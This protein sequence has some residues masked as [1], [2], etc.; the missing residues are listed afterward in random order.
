MSLWPNRQESPLTIVPR[1]HGRTLALSI[2]GFLGPIPNWVG[3]YNARDLMSYLAVSVAVA[4]QGVALDEA[5][6]LSGDAVKSRSLRAGLT[7]VLA[8]VTGMSSSTLAS[9][10]I[11]AVRPTDALFAGLAGAVALFGAKRME[12]AIPELAAITDTVPDLRGSH[13]NST[14]SFSYETHVSGR[15]ARVTVDF[16]DSRIGQSLAVSRPDPLPTEAE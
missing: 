11:A 9:E 13:L 6:R 16:L 14:A 10:G 8:A 3:M 4:S 12:E 1:E 5:S 2:L 7:G 15:P